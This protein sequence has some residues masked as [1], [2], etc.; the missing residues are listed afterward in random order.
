MT[1][2]VKDYEELTLDELYEILKI[3]SKVFVLEQNYLYQDLDDLD[4]NAIHIFIQDSNVI[5]AYLR[6]IPKG[7]SNKEVMIGSVLSQKRH[8]GIG[9]K[10][11]EFSIDVAKMKL[12]ADKIIVY[13]Q[14]YAKRF[15]E[16]VGFIQ[17][18][19]E[20]LE[21]K[22]PHIEMTFSIK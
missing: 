11:L 20:F 6:V 5:Q 12:N 15:Y 14:S 7:N 21:D 22:I 8:C 19:E 9:T 17:T 18:S 2:V 3:R 13:A 10:V 1:Y 16:N 4:K